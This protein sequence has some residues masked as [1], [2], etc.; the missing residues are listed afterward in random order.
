MIKNARI[1]VGKTPSAVSGAPSQTIRKGEALKR[2]EKSE[3][4]IVKTAKA[5]HSLVEE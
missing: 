2:D 3:V 1:E 5:L 4:S